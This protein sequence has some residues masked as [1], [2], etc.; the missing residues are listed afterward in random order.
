MAK[1]LDN[2]QVAQN[3]V[4]KSEENFGKGNFTGLVELILLDKKAKNERS[5]TLMWY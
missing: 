4:R 5:R 3:D 2:T 1:I